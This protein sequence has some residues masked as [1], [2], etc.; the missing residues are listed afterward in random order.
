VDFHDKL[1]DK[2]AARELTK[3]LET[4]P[5]L[6]DNS[7]FHKVNIHSSFR[8]ITWGDLGVRE[9]SKAVPR[10]MEIA[11]QTATLRSNYVVSTKEGE[12]TAYYMV[13]EY[14]RL[15]YTTDRMYLLDFERTMTQIP[16]AGKMCGNDK[17]LLGITDTE[18]PMVESE[19]G[20]VVVF[21]VA[22]RLFSYDV[23]SNKLAVMRRMQ[24]L[25]Q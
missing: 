7:S 12:Y 23:E 17:L 2:E 4:D 21:E 1:Y 11:E 3:Y 24:T 14:Y 9:V 10:F 22:G 6:E 16:D 5:K 25:G 19:D 20:N 13:E 18:I 15:R 8:Q